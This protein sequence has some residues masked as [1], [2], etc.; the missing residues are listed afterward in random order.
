MDKQLI[1]VLD[2]F[3]N[4]KEVELVSILPSKREEK[5]YLVYSDG[6]K[7]NDDMVNIYFSILVEDE[8]GLSIKAIES[9]EELDYVNNLLMSQ[10]EKGE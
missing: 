4:K 1:T 6:V 9:D 2:E 10:L 8:N 5:V 3:G 7:N